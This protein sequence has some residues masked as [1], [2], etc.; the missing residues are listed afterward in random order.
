MSKSA[1]PCKI[2]GYCKLNCTAD[3]CIHGLDKQYMRRIV[4]KNSNF[5]V[6]SL[7][8][9]AGICTLAALVSFDKK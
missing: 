8:T 2:L 1:L 5:P 9:L 6:Y 4:L 3:K 7:Y